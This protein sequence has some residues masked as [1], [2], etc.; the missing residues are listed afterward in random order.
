MSLDKINNIYFDHI[1]YHVISA[2]KVNN[3]LITNH[4]DA[5]FVFSLIYARNNKNNMYHGR[6]NVFFS[7]L[8]LTRFI[9]LNRYTTAFT[10]KIIQNHD[11]II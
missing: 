3:K 10:I 11:I 2:K 4:Q 6:G 9:Y 1:I 8:E 7:Y 5:Y